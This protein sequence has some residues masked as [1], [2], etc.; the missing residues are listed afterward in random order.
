MIVAPLFSTA[1]LVE[2][3]VYLEHT[4]NT[5][6]RKK[7]SAFFVKIIEKRKEMLYN[8]GV[9]FRKEKHLYESNA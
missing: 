8:G 4:K 2:P 9:Y 5:A 7:R 3:G 1:P 6:E